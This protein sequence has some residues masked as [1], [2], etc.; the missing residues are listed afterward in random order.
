MTAA[1]VTP[2]VLAEKLALVLDLD[3]AQKGLLG[4]AVALQCL[5][6]TDPRRERLFMALYHSDEAFDVGDF[7]AGARHEMEFL[8]ALRELRQ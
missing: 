3:G 2:E 4:I 8:Q 1:D 6:E 5:S 7:K